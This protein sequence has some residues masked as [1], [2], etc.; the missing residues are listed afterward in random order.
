VADRVRREDGGTAVLL[1][2]QGSQH[3][4]MGRDLAEARPE[5]ARLYERADE[6]LG[7]PIRRISW[8]GPEEELTRTENAQPAILLHSFAVWRVLPEAVREDVRI[9]AGHSL[10]EFTAYLVADALEFEDALRLVRRRGE[11]MAESEGGTMA[12][13]LGLADEEVGELC[14]R[15]E[16]G[17]VVPANFNSPGQVVI[18]G[19]PEAVERAGE[20]ARQAGA[21]RVIPLRVSGAFHSPLME[22][23]REGLEEALSSVEIDD[24]AFPVVANATAEPVTSAEDARRLLVRQLTAPV[25]WADGLRRMRRGAPERWL[26]LGPGSVLAGLARRIDRELRVRAVSGPEELT[27]LEESGDPRAGSLEAAPGGKSDG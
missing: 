10:G 5:V 4:G 3:L 1:P 23:A 21:R 19:E 7:V 20:L 17:V 2:G 9:A 18:S 27:S 13:I 26:E 11:L 24:P 12:A 8:E 25:R 14:D 6:V 22:V 15:V 16:V